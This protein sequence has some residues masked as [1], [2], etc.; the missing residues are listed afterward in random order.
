MKD[1]VL[2]I[3]EGVSLYGPTSSDVLRLEEL[4]V[5]KTW[6]GA[7]KVCIKMLRESTVISFGGTET[8]C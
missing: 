6:R 5:Q 4:T 3:D 7:S 1:G 2:G 8:G